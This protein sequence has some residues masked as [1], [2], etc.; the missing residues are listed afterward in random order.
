MLQKLGDGFSVFQE[1][2]H[3]FSTPLTSKYKVYPSNVF[4][5]WIHKKILL[6]FIPFVQWDKSYINIKRTQF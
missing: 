6:N 3:G 1:N 2:I 4:N 5:F